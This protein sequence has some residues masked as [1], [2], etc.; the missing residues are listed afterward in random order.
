[1]PQLLALV[2]ALAPAGER[3]GKRRIGQGADVEYLLVL[4]RPLAAQAART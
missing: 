4:A 3:H 2:P 1:M